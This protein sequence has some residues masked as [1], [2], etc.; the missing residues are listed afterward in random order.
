M[1]KNEEGNEPV[2]FFCFF[3]LCKG[4]I[5]PISTKTIVLL[6]KE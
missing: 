5:I 2:P 3:Y 6:R 1:M 4:R